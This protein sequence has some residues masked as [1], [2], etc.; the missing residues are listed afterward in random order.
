MRS[1]RILYRWPACFALPFADEGISA[2]TRQAHFELKQA[3]KT[4]YLKQE[5]IEMAAGY[6][7]IQDF[8]VLD[9]APGAIPQPPADLCV[10]RS[11]SEMRNVAPALIASTRERQL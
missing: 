5:N 2:D 1:P 4:R 7:A 11:K 6:S 8:R 3:V 10:R 9:K